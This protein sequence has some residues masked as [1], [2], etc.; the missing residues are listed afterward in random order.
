MTKD[1]AI[2]KV[3]DIAS[4][5]VGYHEKAS[6]SNLDDFSANSG[7]GNFTKYA[8]DIDA[9]KSFYNGH[10]QGIAWCDV[11]VDWCFVKAFGTDTGRKMLYQPEKS[12]GA[13]CK[14]SS[15]YFKNASEF[16][17]IPEMGDQIFFLTD[18][19][20]A[21]TGIVE[22]VTDAKVYTIEGNSDDQVKKHTYSRSSARIGGYGRPNWS[23]V[24]EE[25]EPMPVLYEAKVVATSGKTVNLRAKPSDS[26]TV[27][28]AVPIGSTVGVVEAYNE[29]WSKIRWNNW[30]GYMMTK[31]LKI[32]ES[33]DEVVDYI[34]EKLLELINYIDSK[35]K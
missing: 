14:S 17:S 2:Q 11:F 20:Y 34:R 15:N 29:K 13:G 24:S 30:E 5:Q 25:E 23:L 9:I 10:K 28:V 33:D 21:H 7:S 1:E 12:A 8:R 26:S 27:L 6:E 18:G 4:S 31:F 35:R 32:P 19:E 3:L 22:R 16:Y